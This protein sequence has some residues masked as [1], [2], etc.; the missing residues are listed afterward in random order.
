MLFLVV[1]FLVVVVLPMPL[2][3][4]QT[5]AKP[6]V[7]GGG[8]GSETQAFKVVSPVAVLTRV[9]EKSFRRANDGLRNHR[10]TV[11]AHV[12]GAIVDCNQVLA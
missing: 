1:R 9:V 4:S 12:S 3:G 8:H 5:A 2:I 10:A 11:A 6:K 7:V